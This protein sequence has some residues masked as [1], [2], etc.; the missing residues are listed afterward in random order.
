MLLFSSKH[1]QQLACFAAINAPKIIH[2]LS[3]VI[4]NPILSMS[5]LFATST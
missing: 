5:V 3:I 2:Q 4:C 1:G